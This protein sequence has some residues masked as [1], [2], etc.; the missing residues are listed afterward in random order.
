MR[1]DSVVEH[2]SLTF[3]TYMYSPFSCEISATSDKE[4]TKTC[5]LVEEAGKRMQ[6]IAES[7]IMLWMN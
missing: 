7:S 4:M 1:M 3:V 2:R 6:S 5:R